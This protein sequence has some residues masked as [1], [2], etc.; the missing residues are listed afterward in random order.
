MTKRVAVIG[1][2]TIGASW[3]AIFLARGLEV[4]ALEI[5]FFVECQAARTH[6]RGGGG[7]EEHEPAEQESSQ[8]AWLETGRLHLRAFEP[9]RYCFLHQT[10]LS[11]RPE[12]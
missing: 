7:T 6:R 10:E 11:A 5:G 1:A 9:T 4:A 2:G 8:V 3:A 12:P